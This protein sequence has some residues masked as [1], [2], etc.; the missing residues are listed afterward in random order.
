MQFAFDLISDLHVDK[1]RNFDWSSQATSPVCVVAGNA[2]LGHKATVDVLRHL[3]QCYHAVFYI[4]GTVEHNHYQ[5]NLLL[6]YQQLTERISLIPKVVYLQDNVVVLNGVALLATNGWWNF[7]FDPNVDTTESELWY[8]DEYGVDDI[9]CEQIK[10]MSEFDTRY[11]INGIR[12]LQTH[13]DVK[14]IVIVTHTVPDPALIDHDISLCHQPVFNCMGNR[15]MMQAMAADTERKISTWC[16]GHYGGS[17]DQMRSGIRF[18]NNP[19]GRP[20]DPYPQLSYY[21]RRITI[22][23]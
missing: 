17:V 13:T 1:W 22:D 12:R 20:S 11:M 5:S 6:S 10:N 3:S 18:V 2:A 9:V 8:M 21:P 15:T 7:D 19:R 23:I 16:F 4:D 14:K